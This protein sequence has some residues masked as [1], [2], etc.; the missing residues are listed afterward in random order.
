MTPDLPARRAIEAP[1]RTYD[2]LNF[3]G[4]RLPLNVPSDPGR[5]G[6]GFAEAFRRARGALGKGQTFK[7]EEYGYYGSPGTIF[8]TNYD[9]EVAP[10]TFGPPIN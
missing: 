8:T 7:G 5:Q 4:T 2:N 3:T 9:Y 6:G 10:G 1:E